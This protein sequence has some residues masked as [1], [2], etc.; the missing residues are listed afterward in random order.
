MPYVRAQHIM[1][2]QFIGSWYYFRL[3]PSRYLCVFG[4]RE[5]WGLGCG[6]RGFMGTDKQRLDTS[7]ILLV[8]KQM[9]R[10]LFEILLTMQRYNPTFLKPVCNRGRT[11]SVKRALYGRVE[12]RSFDSRSEVG[13]NN[14][15]LK[16]TA[17]HFLTQVTT[18][19]TNGGPV[20]SRRRRN[21]VY[22]SSKN[23]HFQIELS[24]SISCKN[25]F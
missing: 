16:I 13:G 7:L 18:H 17:R 3:V 25:E 8:L 1:I 11:S 9:A 2:G 6:A 24:E 14:Q 5:D 20:S 12:G 15:G 21:A 4:V 19:C 10:L 23:S 22:S